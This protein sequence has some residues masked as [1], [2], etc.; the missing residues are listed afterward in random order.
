MTKDSK[1]IQ[2]PVRPP[3]PA[4]YDKAHKD[5]MLDENG[6]GCIPCFVSNRWLQFNTM[7][8]MCDS[9][10]LVMMNVMTLSK[11]GYPHRLCEMVIE[12]E[13]LIRVYKTIEL[14]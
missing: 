13:D 7:S 8:D 11:N 14:L 9:K 1:I 4:N 10:E 6:E 3:K 5:K 2:F 12:K